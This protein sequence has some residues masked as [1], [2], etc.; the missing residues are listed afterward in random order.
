MNKCANNDNSCS[1]ILYRTEDG[2]EVKRNKKKFET[3]DIAIITAKKINAME[4][5]IHKLV[6]YKCS[7][8]GFYHIGHT[9]KVLTDKDKMKARIFLKHYKSKKA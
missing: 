6:A 7:K 5:T 4:G 3:S 2:T 1:Y 9:N 8:C